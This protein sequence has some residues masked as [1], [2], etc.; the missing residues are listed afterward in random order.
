MTGFMG[1]HNSHFIAHK[2]VELQASS[3]LLLMNPK[4]RT[5]S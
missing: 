4:N 5:N 2:K 1:A 3:N